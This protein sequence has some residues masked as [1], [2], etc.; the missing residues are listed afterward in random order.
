M[1]CIA[2]YLKRR[3]LIKKYTPDFEQQLFMM[4]FWKG[5][6]EFLRAF[7]HNIYCELRC[8]QRL[9]KL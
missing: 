4:E 1:N 8:L 2:K 7:R 5:D 9:R 6:K 3:R